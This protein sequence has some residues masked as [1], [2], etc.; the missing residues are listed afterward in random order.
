MLKIKLARFGKKHQPS[1][2]IVVVEARK[3]RDGQYI[4]AIGF[5]NPIVKPPMIKINQER[6]LYWREKG[7]QPTETVASLAKKLAGT[8]KKSS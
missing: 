3:K 7:A 6:Y 1:Y 5:Y 2:R 8:K 4:E